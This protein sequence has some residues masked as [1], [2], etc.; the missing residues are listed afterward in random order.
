MSEGTQQGAAQDI[1]QVSER[2]YALERANRGYRRALGAVAIAVVAAVSL[3]LKD[4]V[5][6]VVRSRR[7]EVVDSSGRVVAELGADAVGGRLAVHA[8]NGG[9]A[10]F[11]TNAEG[12]ALGLMSNDGHVPVR[13]GVSPKGGLL[14]VTNRADQFVMMAAAD[15]SSNGTMVLFDREGNE[16]WQAP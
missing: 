7:F 1:Q 12:G 14:V 3:A 13:A 5:P 4:G 2:L 9:G 10:M 11:F 6:D 8:R 15:D 16:R